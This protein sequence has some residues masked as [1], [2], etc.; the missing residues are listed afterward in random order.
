MIVLKIDGQNFSI[1]PAAIKPGVEIIKNSE[2][3]ISG[4]M[5]IDFV[6]QKLNLEIVWD[7]LTQQE[8]EK[9]Q[10]A[11]C[12]YDLKRVEYLVTEPSLLRSSAEAEPEGKQY[13]FDG[14]AFVPA[15]VNG[16]IHYKNVAVKMA[17]A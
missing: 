13:Y 5:C 14:L 11:L 6:A 2:R 15:I 17:E 3:S 7:L 4:K 12:G 1:V 9:V 10:A 16:E 8:F